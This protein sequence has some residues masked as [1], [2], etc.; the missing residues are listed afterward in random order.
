M[1][2]FMVVDSALDGF[3]GVAILSWDELKE[4]IDFNTE[5]LIDSKGKILVG[6][7]RIP[8]PLQKPELY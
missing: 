5:E 6:G 4:S 3:N 8:L 2:S 1:G 7:V